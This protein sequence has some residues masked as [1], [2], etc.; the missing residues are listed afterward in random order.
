MLNSFSRAVPILLIAGALAGA[1]AVRGQSGR[2]GAR[3]TDGRQE[4]SAALRGLV[5]G[6]AS[7]CLP[8]SIQRTASS[9]IYGS[10]IL[11]TASSGLKYRSDTNV[12]CNT[13]GGRV[14]DGILL[15]STPLGSTCA[16][17]PAR[18][19]DRVTGALTGTCSF[20][21]FVPYRRP[22]KR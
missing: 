3:D 17:D 4:L 21:P 15:V 5:P 6:R 16:G 11:F 22:P 18:T 14:D 7:T 9:R 8:A 13:Q 2:D 1:A 12:P 20:G 10:T 19:V